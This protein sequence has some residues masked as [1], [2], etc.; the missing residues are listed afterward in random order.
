MNETLR[1]F[2]D[3]RGVRMRVDRAAG[4]I[5]GVKVLGLH[6]RNGR[7]YL[8]GALCGAVELYEGAKVNVNH[9]AAS[10]GGPRDYRD[11]IGAIRNVSVR[12]DEGLFADLHFNPKHA[13][14]EQLV[15]DAE[16][17]PENVGFSHDVLARTVRRGDQVVVEAI[18]QVRSVDL[19]ADPATTQGLFESSGVSVIAEKPLEPDETAESPLEEAGLPVP[20]AEE[21]LERLVEQQAAELEQLRQE[22]QRLRESE[23]LAKRRLTIR[24][25]LAE[26]G[27]PD[28]DAGDPEAESVVS[29][30]FLKTL[31]AAPDEQ[32][33]GEL[34]AERAEL[35]RGLSRQ[36]P[37]P[38]RPQ[39]REQSGLDQPTPLSTN[40]FVQ[41]IAR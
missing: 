6:S 4:V 17:A 7:V 24:R 37:P 34:I 14:A 33:V 22:V 25:R 26:A 21:T 5:Q 1:E 9:A 31:E 19:V 36:G 27:L 30:C 8:P 13:L 18:T 41:S 2:V 10:T 39:S 15:W 23:S 35:V 11:R 20:E 40:D 38:R 16:N 32:T 29:P 12:T 28:P 3:S